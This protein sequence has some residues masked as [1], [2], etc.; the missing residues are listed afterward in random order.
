MDTLIHRMQKKNTFCFFLTTFYTIHGSNHRHTLLR[1]NASSTEQQQRYGDS[2]CA[3]FVI[4]VGRYTKRLFRE[5][6]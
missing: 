1:H 4:Q 3:D 2:A 5:R 6:G